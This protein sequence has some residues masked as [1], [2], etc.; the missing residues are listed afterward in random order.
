MTASVPLRQSRGVESQK[1]KIENRKP[2]LGIRKWKTEN[3]YLPNLLRVSSPFAKK[4]SQGACA[5]FGQHAGNHLN[6]MIYFGVVEHCQ[7]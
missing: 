2:K 7:G 3:S 4:L 1:W 6:P 5:L